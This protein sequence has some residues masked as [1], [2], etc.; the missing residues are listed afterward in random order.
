MS[1][2]NVSRFHIRLRKNMTASDLGIGMNQQ[3]DIARLL[4][5]SYA[6]SFSR[7]KTIRSAQLICIS[8]SY[9]SAGA[10]ICSTSSRTVCSTGTH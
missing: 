3:K 7:M 2:R 5:S 4:I 10:M 6:E 8:T 1:F 9:L